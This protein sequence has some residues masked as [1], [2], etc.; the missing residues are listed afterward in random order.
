MA[1]IRGLQANWYLGRSTV[2]AL[3]GVPSGFTVG[4]H[5]F[6]L[7]IGVDCLPVPPVVYL[8]IPDDVGKLQAVRADLFSIN[9]VL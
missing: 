1:D 4:T 9:V 6:P 3:A 2:T 8:L 7:S 5:Y